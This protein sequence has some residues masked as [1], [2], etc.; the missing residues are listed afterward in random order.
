MDISSHFPAMFVEILLPA[1]KD[2]RTKHFNCENA[3]YASRQSS[4][5]ICRNRRPL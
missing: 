4:N 3:G 5:S 1:P 2:N